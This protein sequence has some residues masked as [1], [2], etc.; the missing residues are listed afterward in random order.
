MRVQLNN[1]SKEATQALTNSN[2]LMT[3][4][5]A[6][7]KASQAASAD[8]AATRKLLEQIDERIT[9]GKATLK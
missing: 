8:A 7:K 2:Q 6:V 1:T 3:E 4:M 9:A 5:A